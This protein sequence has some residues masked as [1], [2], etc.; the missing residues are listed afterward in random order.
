NRLSVALIRN[1]AGKFI[2][3]TLASTTAAVAGSAAALAKDVRNPIANSAAPDAYPIAGLTF[4]LV[5]Q[6]SKD[7]A[8]AKALAEFIGWAIHDG[9]DMVE[10]LDYARLP[11]GVVKVD[12][13]TLRTLTAG[14]K[15]VMP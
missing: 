11:E 4:L 1:K 2:E 5:Y 15:K 3:P 14:G 8:R 12:E 10:S 6:D 7:A 9:Q 13:A